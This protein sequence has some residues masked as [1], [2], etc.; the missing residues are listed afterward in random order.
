MGYAQTHI[1]LFTWLAI[2]L[3]IKKKDY[4]IKKTR[5]LKANYNSR[6]IFKNKIMCETF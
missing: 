2:E 1:N 5:N 6:I 3:Y 4:L